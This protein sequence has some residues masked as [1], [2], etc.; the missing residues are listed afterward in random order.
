MLVG[1][2]GLGVLTLDRVVGWGPFTG[3]ESDASAQTQSGGTSVEG[4]SPGER[5]AREDS[6]GGNNSGK[7]HEVTP[8]N[9][10]DGSL[11]ESK[12]WAGDGPP[13]AISDRRLARR[14]TLI[15]TLEGADEIKI[16]GF[17]YDWAAPSLPV[18]VWV[19]VDGHR[20]SGDVADGLREIGIGA[21]YDVQERGFSFES[22]DVLGDGREHIV[23]VLARVERDDAFKEI[24][25]SPRTVG[26]NSPP[27]GAVMEFRAGKLI[28]WAR[29]AE[30][31]GQV[32]QL[33]IL[34]DGKRLGMWQANHDAPS[35]L[36]APNPAARWFTAALTPE[37]KPYRV[38]VFALDPDQT[39]LRRELEGS[40]WTLAA[41][42][43]DEDE[44]KDD[45]GEED[46]QLPFGVVAFIGIDQISGWAVDP[47]A[48][49]APIEVELY[50][51]GLL[52]GRVLA[53]GPFP[54]LLHNP[55]INSINHLWLVDVPDE[56]K[57]GETHM[58]S[59][60]AVNFP[61]GANPE[62]SG[63]PASFTGRRNSEPVGFLDYVNTQKIGGW[64]YDADAGANAV[65]VEVWIDGILQ[66]V[67]RAGE[68]RPDLVPA[69]SPGPHHGWSLPAKA[70]LD[71]G[72]FHTVRA[73]VRD[74]PGGMLHE[75]VWSPRELRSVN[76]WL[77][78]S[79]GPGK[80]GRGIEILSL[81]VGGPAKDAG[82]RDSDRIIAHN[83]IKTL[84]DTEAF[85]QW[86]RSRSI[87]DRIVLVVERSEEGRTEER[88]LQ[89]VLG[90]MPSP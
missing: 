76:P 16:W 12:D 60:F 20:V 45:D 4:P 18:E 82:A 86:I 46:N 21:P 15:G 54:A 84:A 81:V 36:V 61:H 32:V 19:Y 2:L 31:P 41:L 23:R 35:D 5:K 80:G 13:D 59:V 53:D 71:D 64:A 78:A 67:L 17:A 65:E 9:S 27:E 40:P 24:H 77:G 34:R 55:E 73:F 47:D 26:G 28:G 79:V 42:N 72:E 62:L 25:G 44:D 10:N 63:S 50:F 88:I 22:P 75:L 83:G 49:G 3:D 89:P 37:E 66:A 43:S 8:G 68:S 39:G 58:I 51:D 56:L 57:D 87:G 38:Q 74:E 11:N 70:L 14:G 48:S 6:G 52:H 30:R 90:L 33:E 29:D 7:N 85:L 69:A 1:F